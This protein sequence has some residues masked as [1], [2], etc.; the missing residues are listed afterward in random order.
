MKDVSFTLRFLEADD[1]TLLGKYLHNRLEDV[2]F[3]L[4]PQL[5]E[6]RQKFRKFDFCGVLLSGS[7]SAVYGLCRS[8]SDANNIGQK[9]KT[10]GIGDVFVVA[11]D[12]EGITK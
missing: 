4:Y 10:F 9:L 6:I 7:G 8:G 12:F 1:A 2:V 3:K 11:S 5:E